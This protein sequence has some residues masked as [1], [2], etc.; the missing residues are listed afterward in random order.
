MS[1]SCLEVK[2]PEFVKMKDWHIAKVAPSYFEI[3]S[4]AQFYNPNK[5][6]VTLTNVHADVFLGNEKLGT[7]NQINSIKVP[8]NSAFEIP[9]LLTFTTEGKLNLVFGN[10]LKL[11]SA[12]TAVINYKGFIELKKA[13][14][15][16]KVDMSD[17]YEFNIKEL[18]IFK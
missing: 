9:L 18:N 12:K 1:G 7:I 15:R 16:L 2:D 8:K 14:I 13:N 4:K 17:K 3:T 11:L 6:G 5:M 10:L